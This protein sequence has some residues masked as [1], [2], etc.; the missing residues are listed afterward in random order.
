MLY[1][2][3]YDIPQLEKCLFV[4]KLKHIPGSFVLRLP[5]GVIIVFGITVEVGV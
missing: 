3:N 2:K 4:T 1:N 5:I